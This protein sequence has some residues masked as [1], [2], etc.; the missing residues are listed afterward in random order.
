MN[1]AKIADDYDAQRAGDEALNKM[2][3]IARKTT[4]N[5]RIGR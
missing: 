1:V 4:A 5:N 3:E 2:L